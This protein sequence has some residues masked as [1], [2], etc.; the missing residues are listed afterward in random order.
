MNL[1]RS[2]WSTASYLATSTLA[3]LPPAAAAIRFRPVPFPI[4]FRSLSWDTFQPTPP[5]VSL[6][7]GTGDDGLE[8]DAPRSAVGRRAQ[9]GREGAAM[10][11]R[12]AELA[13]LHQ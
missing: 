3:L 12:G 7:M 1:Y 4:P 5:L 2:L 8:L 6:C 11:N 9:R 10:A 13:R